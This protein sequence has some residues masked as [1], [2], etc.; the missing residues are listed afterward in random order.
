MMIP[1]PQTPGKEKEEQHIKDLWVRHGKNFVVAAGK[2]LE[3]GSKVT[4][5]KLPTVIIIQVVDDHNLLVEVGSGKKHETWWLAEMETTAGLADEQQHKFAEDFA[6]I[7]TKTYTTVLNAHKT[8][9]L[10]VP[11]A[12]LDRDITLEQFKLVVAANAPLGKDW[13]KAEAERLAKQKAE[14]EARKKK[15]AYD[16]WYNSPEQVAK[17]KAEAEKANAAVEKEA[18]HKLSLAKAQLDDGK[19]Q[20]YKAKTQAV[21][22]KLIEFGR[23]RLSEVI[24]EFPNTKAAAEARELLKETEKFLEEWRAVK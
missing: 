15:E 6:V 8:V 2:I 13:V 21:A 18:A 23:K 10:A 4:P 16:K 24:A 7:G 20:L 11:A 19:A 3:R 17:R 9:P 22:M 5:V 14:E 12:V 1:G